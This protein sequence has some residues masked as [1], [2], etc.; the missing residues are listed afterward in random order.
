[1]SAT[2]EQNG[3]TQTDVDCIEERRPLN[4][5]PR[6][7]QARMTTTMNVINMQKERQIR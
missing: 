3:I 5:E 2:H 7:K 1:M 4:I 6:L